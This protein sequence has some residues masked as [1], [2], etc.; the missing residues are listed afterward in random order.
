VK[1]LVQDKKALAKAIRN[2]KYNGAFKKLP[3]M[4]LARRSLRHHHLC[5]PDGKVSW[6][7]SEY[8]TVKEAS[9]K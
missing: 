5:E 3:L 1:R 2:V 7:T 8:A 4:N 9:K 6:E